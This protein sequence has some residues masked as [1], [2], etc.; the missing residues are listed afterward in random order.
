MGKSLEIKP[1]SDA[2]LLGRRVL[3]ADDEAPTRWSYVGL[4]RDAGARVTEARDGLEALEL[5]RGHRPDLI[6]A[7]IAMPRLDGLGLCA[8]LRREPALDGVTVVL[9]SDGGP[10]QAV[11]GSDTESRPLVDAVVGVLTRHEAPSVPEPREEPETRLKKPEI[12]EDSALVVDLVERENVRAQS[13][14]AMHGEPANRLRR[15]APGV[16][17]F[18]ASSTP[19]AD[20]STSRFGVELGMMSRVLG[21]GFI[22]LLAGTIGLLVWHQV[23]LVSATESPG[24]APEPAK[25]V[26]A[27]PTLEPEVAEDLGLS[28]FSGVL[29]PGV[30]PS[31]GASEGQGVL[32]VEGPSDVKITVD[33]IDHGSLPSSFALDEGLHVVRYRFDDNFTDRFYYVKSG[34]TRALRVITRPGGF[35]DAR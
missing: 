10:P 26:P 19:Q 22:G 2:G 18:R 35:V 32:E 24:S 9:L 15:S 6:V 28:A 17:R 8:A 23:I 34:A 5:A 14:V 11:W 27:T 30:D 1:L 4:L 7:D 29:R 21:V 16:W 3:V 12:A 33:G 13:T 20:G 25:D 31:I